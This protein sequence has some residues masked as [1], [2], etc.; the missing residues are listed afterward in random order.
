MING[1]IKVFECCKSVYNK[2][3]SA[4][5]STGSPSANY[6]IDRNNSTFWSSIG[7]DDATVETITITL[8]ESSDIDRLLLVDHNFKNYTIKYFDGAG[9]VDFTS[10]YKYSIELTQSQLGHGASFGRASKFSENTF[11]VKTAS[12]TH[13]LIDNENTLDVTYFEFDSVTTMS[14]RI[15]VQSTQVA[16]EEK[17]ISQVIAT[18][19]LGTMQGFPKVKVKHNTNNSERKALSG[20]SLIVK[21]RKATK[22]SL[23]LASY[24]LK[25]NYYLDTELLQEL[26]DSDD[27]FMIWLC[28][29]RG[30]SYFS[31]PFEGFRLQDIYTMNTS[32][33]Y[34]PEYI[35]NI[36]VNGINFNANFKEVI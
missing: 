15:E 18:A 6:A 8:S 22:L 7:S 24:P 30:D 9:Y 34:Q 20:R 35:E 19:E 26:F 25:D 11:G 10:A 5:A 23:G 27:D 21:N 31:Y 3:A 2:G 17:H 28:G 32:G 29:G 1:G 36:Y 4:I 13:S 16:D 33:D 14:I 12:E